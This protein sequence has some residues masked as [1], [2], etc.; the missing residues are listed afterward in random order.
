MSG[1]LHELYQQV[2][3]D[4]NRNPRNLRV[5]NGGRRGE[6]INPICGDRVTVHLRVEADVIRD[7][8]FQASGCAIVKASASLMTESIK[9]LTLAD[10]G[11]L[12]ERLLP[13]IAAPPGAP[14]EDL[15]TLTALAGVRW[16][17]IRVKCAQLPWHAMRAAANARED[18]VST[19]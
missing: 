17:P 9:G 14:I 2:I 12:A 15:G 6:G 5:I 4:H 11:A 1:E 18:V 13:M 7:A 16:F 10:A 3:L 8:S 19:E